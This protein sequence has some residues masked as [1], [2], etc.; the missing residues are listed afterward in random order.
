MGLLDGMVSIDSTLEETA[1]FFSKVGVTLYIPTSG[2][3]ELQ[4]FHIFIYLLLSLF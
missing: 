2:V 3:W 4:V 1:K